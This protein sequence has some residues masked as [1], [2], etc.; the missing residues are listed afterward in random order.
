GVKID[1]SF[2]QDAVR[3]PDALI[4]VESMIGLAHALGLSATAEGVEDTTTLELL[5]DLGCDFAQG[6]L[7]APP[8]DPTELA[9]WLLRSAPRWRR[10]AGGA[11]ARREA[12]FAR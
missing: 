4:I 9:P 5:R 3:D 10:L 7:F 1:L 12:I 6:F 11:P 2:V 8:L